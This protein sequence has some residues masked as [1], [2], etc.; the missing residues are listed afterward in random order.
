MGH[1]ARARAR[2]LSPDVGRA[3]GARGS[4]VIGGMSAYTATPGER[5]SAVFG[6]VRDQLLAAGLAKLH[7]PADLHLTDPLAGQVEDLAHLLEGDAPDLRDVE[8]AGLLELP[9]FLIGEVDLDAAR[10]G[11]HV[12]VQ[13]VLAADIRAG[14]RH[15][16]AFASGLGTPVGALR[17]QQRALLVELGIWP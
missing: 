7:Q 17:V 11:V 13:M 3:S 9:Y 16:G 12:D 10:V 6:E 5:G 8:G 15:V 1:R 4:T 14:A 2:T